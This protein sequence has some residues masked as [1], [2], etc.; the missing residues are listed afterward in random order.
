MENNNVFEQLFEATV[1]ADSLDRFLNENMQ[2]IYELYNSKHDVV[3]HAKDSIERFILLKCNSL[4]KLDFSQSYSR[5]LALMLLDFC[6]RFNFVSATPRMCLILAEQDIPLNSRMQAALLFLYPKPSTNTE[7]VEKFESL[8]AKLQLAIDTEEDNNT[9]AVATFLNYYNNVIYDTSF[10][11]AKQVKSKI[12]NAIQSNS[13]EFL[14]E[15]QGLADIQ[16]NDKEAAYEQ[17]QNLIDSVLGRVASTKGW[18][19]ET[20]DDCV[21]EKGTDYANKLESTPCNFDAIRRISVN[22]ANGS[23]ITNRGVKILESEEELFIYLKSFGNMHKAKVMSA[24]EKPFPQDFPSKMNVVDWGCGQG[25]ASM[26]FLEKFGSEMVNQITLVEPSEVAIKRAALHCKKYAPRTPVKTIC[27]KLNDLTV[28]D[29]SLS[30][31]NLTVH[32]FS[33][34]LDIDDYSSSHLIE[35]IE[36]IQRGKN[37]YVCVSPH[38]DDIKTGKL[39]TFKRYFESNYQSFHLLKEA[40]NTKCGNFWCCNNT[41]K[42]NSVN[43][44]IYPNCCKSDADG[45][46]N[47]WT[48]V[49]KVFAVTK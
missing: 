22:C 48:R 30:P 4:S 13:Y 8:C 34:I 29:F 5:A 39:E 3:L 28:D 43:H 49:V 12:T 11:F 45:C 42:N 40:I 27:K 19:I 15:I 17:I 36:S 21:I 20:F 1:S 33:N 24:F 14:K 26:L 46:A 16:I 2:L 7:L 9:K 32:L 31:M 35:I 6:E 38:I 10:E 37:F 47:K 25:L 18:Q 23:S 44:G 41:Y